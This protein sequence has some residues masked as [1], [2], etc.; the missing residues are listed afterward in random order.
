MAAEPA[1]RWKASAWMVVLLALLANDN[2][3]HHHEFEV[4]FGD[5]L[6]GYGDGCLA[7]LHGVDEP[8]SALMMANQPFNTEE[9]F[10]KVLCF[11]EDCAD[12][13]ALMV[14]DNFKETLGC[15]EST[16]L[17]RSLWIGTM[18][19]WIG[20]SAQGIWYPTELAWRIGTT[21][22]Y[23]RLQTLPESSMSSKWHCIAFAWTSIWTTWTLGM[24]LL[25]SWP[26]T[27]CVVLFIFTLFFMNKFK[28]AVRRRRL[29]RTSRLSQYQGAHRKVC[30]WDGTLA[31]RWSSYVKL[32]G[33]VFLLMYTEVSAM[34]AAQAA[35]LLGRIMELS[36]AATTQDLQF[37][38]G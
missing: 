24:T 16:R 1:W 15:C 23:E 4:A 31:S 26:K 3:L 11:G 28:A 34:D 9:I 13:R 6:D 7:P 25:F 5:H 35:D 17:A 30:R 8:D 10:D 32:Q 19:Q 29:K 2:G 36:T 38:M 22:H 37:G 20:P 21:A 27:S 33:L 12:L 14:Y 18:V